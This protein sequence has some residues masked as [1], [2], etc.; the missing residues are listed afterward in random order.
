MQKESTPTL[1]WD[2]VP[3]YARELALKAAQI[4][5]VWDHAQSLPLSANLHYPG[6]PRPG[7]PENSLSGSPKTF[8]FGTTLRAHP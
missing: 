2:Y 8:A 1:L 5:R 3:S 4:F 7:T 6:S